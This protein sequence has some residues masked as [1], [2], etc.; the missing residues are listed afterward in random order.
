VAEAP[1]P[2]GGQERFSRQVGAQLQRKLRARTDTTRIVPFGLG[3]MGLVGWTVTVPTL[4][5]AAVG[6]WLD[7][8]HVGGRSWTLA[9]LIA[10]LTVGCW[11]AWRWI[12][13]EMA[14]MEGPD[15]D[16]PP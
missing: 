2:Q 12:A 13:R 9:L 6:W 1:E 7:R 5:G 15:H 4:L 14:A 3:M 16:A 11:T 8:H 10:G